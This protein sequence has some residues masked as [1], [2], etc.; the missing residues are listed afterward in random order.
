MQVFRI[1]LTGFRPSSCLKLFNSF[2]MQGSI[3]QESAIHH[4]SFLYHAGSVSPMGTVPIW[5]ASR[6]DLNM[7]GARC[8]CTR[9]IPDASSASFAARANRGAIT[10]KFFV[11]SCIITG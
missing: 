2:L 9:F 3:K 10:R 1:R 6:R 5:A 11:R 8:S 4:I 7:L